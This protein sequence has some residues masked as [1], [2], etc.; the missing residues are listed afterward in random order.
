MEKG[1]GLGS[2][3]LIT[4]ASIIGLVAI[5]CD[6]S[7]TSTFPGA[8]VDASTDSPGGFGSS[9]GGSS[10]GSTSGEGGT[11]GAKCEPV[12]A[13][14]YKASWTK[15]TDPASPGPCTGT[16]VGTY[17]D[18]C[19]ATLGEADHKTR[20]D[21]WKAANAACGE[22]IE[23]TNNS[24]PIQWH[25]E[26][27]Y[28]TL[29]VAGCIGIGQGNKFADSECAYAYGAAINCARDACSGCF[30]TNTSTFDDFRNCQNAAKLVGLCK[31]LNTQVGSVCSDIQTATETKGC[32]NEN[33]SE[34]PRVHYTR[35]MGY[36]CAKP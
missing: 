4:C 32:F 5:A 8:T 28:Y 30:E 21:A 7:G 1:F 3:A 29:N 34:Q 10:S 14:D 15:P 19:L 24:G 2:V 27:Y 33:N 31:S 16:T 22:C 17:Y 20:C 26:R 11:P 9:S 25:Q 35:V 13:N 23:P 12:I 18:E 36:F 6:E